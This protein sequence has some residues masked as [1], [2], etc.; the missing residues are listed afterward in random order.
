M[1]DI[2]KQLAFVYLG[3]LVEFIDFSLYPLLSVPLSQVF[4]A[5]QTP[6][7]AL[8]AT[9]VIFSLS[10]F[11]R[12]LG[13]LYFGALGN[14]LGSLKSMK[15][16]LGLMSLSSLGMCLLPS[17]TRMGIMAPVLLLFLRILQGFSAGGCAPTAMAHVYTVAPKKRLN[18]FCTG[19]PSA[20]L[21]GIL[22][23]SSVVLVLYLFFKED[24]IIQ[25]AWKVP[26][27]VLGVLLLGLISL[28][29]NTQNQIREKPTEKLV[30]GKYIKPFLVCFT[31]NSFQGAGF[32][33]LFVWLPSFMQMEK[34]MDARVIHTINTVSMAVYIGI[35]LFVSLF[36]K[37]KNSHGVIQWGLLLCIIFMF[38][39]S[40]LLTKSSMMTY[41]LAE[42]LIVLLL[43]IPGACLIAYMLSLF[44]EGKQATFVGFAYSLSNALVVGLAPTLCS[45]L[46]NFFHKPQTAILLLLLFASAGYCINIKKPLIQ[47]M[48]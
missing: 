6:Q 26:F 29:L 25:W 9:F 41:F 23:S 40:L 21:L 24:I 5:G 18:F 28:P 32:Y 30:I 14:K 8:L 47:N 39:I 38:P 12:P 1:H 22:L 13:S 36:I 11:V 33:I 37:V 44:P 3:I 35:L 10:F 45:L 46:V 43:S 48:G 42:L 2:K 17:S 20:S 31:L 27:F 19:I 7:V 4:F 34:L 15:V 16:S